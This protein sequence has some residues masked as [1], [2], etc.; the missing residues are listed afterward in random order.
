[1]N[2]VIMIFQLVPTLIAAMKAI[3]EAIPGQG[4]GEQKLALVR[5]ILEAGYGNI[6]DIWPKLKPVI[7]LIVATFN[8]SGV[9]KK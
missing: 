7:D 6:T 4:A 3:E 2:T 9:F 1:M 5:G 8:S